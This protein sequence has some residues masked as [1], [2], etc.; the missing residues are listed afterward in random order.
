[1][2]N[3]TANT[4]AEQRHGRHADAFV[5][6]SDLGEYVRKIN[7]LLKAAAHTGAGEREEEAWL[8]S[9]AWDQAIEMK[10]MR[11]GRTA[12]F[13]ASAAESLLS[14]WVEGTQALLL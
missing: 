3:H 11:T 13:R 4:S 9:L 10:Q 14:Q 12:P 2:Q 8:V 5:T 1:M 6:L 7:A